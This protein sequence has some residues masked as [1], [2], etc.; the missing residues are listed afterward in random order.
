[1]KIIAIVS[2]RVISVVHRMLGIF[3]LFRILTSQLCL[4]K[5]QLH[6]ITATIR[7]SVWRVV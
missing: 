3:N 7:K 1:M 4:L 2:H 5:F 6:I